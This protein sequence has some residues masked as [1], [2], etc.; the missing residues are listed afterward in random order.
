MQRGLIE[1]LLV[2]V[3][4]VAV[5]SS[6]LAL[7]AR[8][9]G[10]LDK[11]DYD[12]IDPIIDVQQLI[13]QRYVEAP[14]NQALQDAAIAGMVEALNDP[15]TSY[16]PASDRG[17]FRKQLTGEYAG[18]GA[19]VQVKEGWLTIVTPLEDSPAF[20]L[21]LMADDR[22][23]EIDGESTHN[24][25]VDKCVDRLTG[26]AGKPVDL[27]IER[28]GE[29]FP[30][31]VVRERIKTRAVKGF[32][33]AQDDPNGWLYAID[34]A[35][36]VAYIRLTQF[37]P[38]CAGELLHA[39]QA[40]ERETA[41]LR[42]LVIDLRNNPG[43][44]LADAVHIADFFLKDGTIVSTRGR[45]HE[46]E[47]ARA[48]EPGT[49]PEFPIAV[50]VNESSASASE[51]LAGALVEN[52]RAVVVGTRSFGKGSVQTVHELEHGGGELKL[53]EQGY[54]L[55]SGRSLTR[56]DDS[57]SWGVDPTPGFYVPM[58]D[59]ELVEMFNVRRELEVLSKDAKPAPDERWN[60][61]DWVL[62]RLKDK[63]LAAAVRAVQGKIDRGEWTI[64]GDEH[65]QKGKL[66][67]AELQRSTTFRQRL[68]REL[69]RLD[70]RIAALQNAVP[71]EKREPES[72]IPKDAAIV[73]GEL[74]I[75]DKEGKVVSVLEIT[76]TNLERWLLD[77]D[78]RRKPAEEPE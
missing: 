53:T 10:G 6:T 64:A 52:N 43:G 74:R 51:V 2:V 25:S 72:L 76:G 71:E 5:V 59:D 31:T 18:I 12:F 75:L 40:A 23:V 8:G 3:L 45:V 57:D 77:A 66:Q 68:E 11:S 14:D 15:Y 41:G 46:E 4:G 19:Q 67:L 38:G 33:R 13:R 44:V 54:Y 56:K 17:E 26:E 47:V 69:I 28:K 24:L 30:L 27:V 9:S 62:E 32:H 22:V 35:R 60:E 58:S 65:E 63:Q 42:G 48:R 37:T 20:R 49:L 34:P 55:P 7:S 73:G 16:I 29:R 21:G 70:K 78:V 39:L 50:L 36:K 61:T 1:R